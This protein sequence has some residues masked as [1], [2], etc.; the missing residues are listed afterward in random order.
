MRNG[1]AQWGKS[2]SRGK[3]VEKVFLSVAGAENVLTSE[4]GRQREEKIFFE[5]LVRRGAY[6]EIERRREYELTNDN[7]VGG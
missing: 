7:A 6:L 1:V 2:S 4:R 5:E 3:L